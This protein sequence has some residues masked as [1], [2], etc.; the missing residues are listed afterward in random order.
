VREEVEHLIAGTTL[1]YSPIVPCST[2]TGDGL[3]A[4]RDTM[5]QIVGQWEKPQPSGYFRLPVDRVFVLHGHG[6]V[7]TGTAS[8]GEISVG[9][10][11]RSLPGGQMFRVR[12]LQVHNEQRE[13]AT[14]GQRVALNLSGH[15]RE[16]MTR[17][18]VI[19]HENLTLTSTR[20]DATLELRRRVKLKSHQRVRVHLGTAERLG[21]IILLGARRGDGQTATF[22]QIVLE[23]PVLALR[24]DRFILR[25]ESAQRTLGGGGVLHPWARRRPGTERGLEEKLNALREGTIPGLVSLF[26]E[27]HE[28]LALP[29]AP[30]A[31][32]LNLP[33]PDAGR[34]IDRLEGVRAFQVDGEILYTTERKWRSL[35]DA[36]I[37]EIGRSHALHPLARGADME[38]LR[39][40]LPIPVPAKLFRTVLEQLERERTIVR[41]GNLVRLPRHEVR[42]QPEEQKLADKILALLASRLPAPPDVRQIAQETGADRQALLEVIRV[43]ERGGSIV[44]VAPDLYFPA[45]FIQSAK[46]ALGGYLSERGTITSATF[47]DVIGTSRKY[48]IPL[49]EY[50]DREGL[51]V[52]V[53]DARRLRNA[54]P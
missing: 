48:A 25:D 42:L 2:V 10:R 40:K 9:D 11:V 33:E 14:W 30:L 49:L 6:L 21:K 36:L 52:R 19:C 46:A 43:L 26:L 31:Q 4:L 29:L 7:V 20:F 27:E 1:E 32:F 54:P 41:E 15:E 12:S 35:V 5:A 34:E 23:D 51:T 39:E 18:D 44:R 17:G 37:E 13:H 16:S 24:G 28:G 22:C 8:S 50:F 3:D 45:E 53:G 38:A 47:R